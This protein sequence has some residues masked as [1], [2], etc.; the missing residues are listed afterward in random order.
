MHAV[1]YYTFFKK[2]I[3]LKILCMFFS[4]QLEHCSRNN[5]VEVQH[6]KHNVEID[7]ATTLLYDCVHGEIFEPVFRPSVKVA[8]ITETYLECRLSRKEYLLQ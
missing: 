8:N 5:E 6:T 4:P 7:V 1:Q 3:G 2:K